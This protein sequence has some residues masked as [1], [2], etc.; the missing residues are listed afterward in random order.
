M[1][2]FFGHA[3][4]IRRVRSFPVM[5]LAAALLGGVSAGGRQRRTGGPSRT[6]RNG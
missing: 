1:S 2:V 6:N 5:A 3:T 4:D